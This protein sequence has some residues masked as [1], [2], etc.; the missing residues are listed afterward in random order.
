MQKLTFAA[1]AILDMCVESWQRFP[2]LTILSLATLSD[3]NRSHPGGGF[4]F[5][6]A[7]N[8]LAGL[9]PSLV[10][11]DQTLTTFGFD[12]TELISLVRQLNGKAIDRI[13]PI[14]QALQFGRFWDGYDLLRA[15][16]REVYVNNS[17]IKT[18]A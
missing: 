18:M 12:D 10:R 9:V 8:S 4:V 5:E 13:V 11:K 2:E 17:P 6:V 15:F 16:C 3:F 7:V 1:S 14:G